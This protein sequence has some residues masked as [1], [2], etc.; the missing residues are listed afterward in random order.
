[1]GSP[2]TLSLEA[3]KILLQESEDLEKLKLL[4]AL[5]RFSI[6]CFYFGAL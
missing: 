5:M 4:L 6:A 1:M 2:R 3:E